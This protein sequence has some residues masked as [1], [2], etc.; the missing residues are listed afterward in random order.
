M[1]VLMFK[2]VKALT[3]LPFTSALFIIVMAATHAQARYSSSDVIQD[4][5]QAL[6]YRQ[7]TEHAKAIETLKKIIKDDPSFDRAYSKLI[8]LYQ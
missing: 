2:V 6:R 5:N 3:L 7:A 4:Y 1:T 8:L